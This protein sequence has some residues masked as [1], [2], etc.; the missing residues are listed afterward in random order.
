MAPLN[1][2]ARAEEL[3]KRG[4]ELYKQGN[5]AAGKSSARSSVPNKSNQI[6]SGPDLI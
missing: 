3:R 6:K 5:L 4:N 2:E 1:E